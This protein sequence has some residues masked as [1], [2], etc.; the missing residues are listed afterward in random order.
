MLK[1]DA[2]IDNLLSEK[3]RLVVNL[4]LKNT[5]NSPK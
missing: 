4:V 3:D 5:S 2:I 1:S